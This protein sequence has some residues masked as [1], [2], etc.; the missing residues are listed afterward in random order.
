M[1]S[2]VN[3]AK[4]SIKYL[5]SIIVRISIIGF[6]YEEYNDYKERKNWNFEFIAGGDA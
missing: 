6:A 2:F 1:D 5:I 3:F 4:K